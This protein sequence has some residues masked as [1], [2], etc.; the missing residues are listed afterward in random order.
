MATDFA[1]LVGTEVCGYE[2]ISELGHGNMGVV[3]LARQTSLDRPVAFKLLLPEYSDDVQY[4]MNFIREA[5]TA[6]Q[7]DHPNIV[8]AL[9]AGKTPDGTSYFVMEYVK[10]RSLEDIRS[11]NPE[12]ITLDFLLGVA[13][14]LA[15]A[16][17]YAWEGFHMTHRDIKP[18]N[19]LI[20]DSDKALKLADL[21]L[22]N[23]QGTQSE[24][25]E[26]M[27]TP[28]YAAPEVIEQTGADVGVRSDIY[29]FGI[30]LY[31]LISGAA[32]FHGEIEEVLRCHLEEV[33]PPLQESN[34][35]ADPELAALVDKMIAKDPYDRPADWLAISRTLS[36]IRDRI[37]GTGTQEL[38]SSSRS[39]N[40]QRLLNTSMAAP[41]KGGQF[42]A[43][44]MAL[45]GGV[46][47][48]LLAILLVY[49]LTSG[50]AS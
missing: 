27:A 21:G 43:V 16:L 36:R 28:M 50:H 4:S 7:L 30:M 48:L 41:A 12:E 26:V 2:L 32:P 29:S 5:R 39:R 23:I 15:S 9:D 14:S 40:I 37:N 11:E 3:Y 31:E 47:F 49:L 22:A 34:P 44:L 19:L 1:N 18:G 35:D 20:R 38:S 33:P 46:A 8:H 25:G 6:A 24:E 42:F 17:H 45:A 10:G 13:I